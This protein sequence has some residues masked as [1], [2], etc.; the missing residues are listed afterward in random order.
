MQNYANYVMN[1]TRDQ[2][3]RSQCDSEIPNKENVVRL[4]GS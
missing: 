1:R 2:T 4:K 3:A